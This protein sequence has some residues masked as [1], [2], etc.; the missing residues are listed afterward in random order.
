MSTGPVRRPLGRQRL[1]GSDFARIYKRGRRARGSSFG[2]VV[3]ENELGRTR[4]GLSVSKRH[5]KQAVHRNRARRLLREA[6][7][8]E[9]A[10]LPVGIDVVLI[11]GEPGKPPSLAELRAELV[12]LVQRALR[13]KPRAPTESR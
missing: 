10:N 5:A 1:L 3:L 4:L 9:H 8:L 12:E 7:R 13:K 2:V 6:F 11:A